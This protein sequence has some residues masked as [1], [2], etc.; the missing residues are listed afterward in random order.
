MDT[1]IH[2]GFGFKIDS[3]FF[4]WKDGV[5]YQ[6]PYEHNGRYFGLRKL[7]RKIS[8]SGWEY[9]HLR[10]KKVGVEKLRAMLQSVDW[11]VTNPHE[12]N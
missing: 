9:Y 12:L 3:V 7:R 10:R 6:L 11:E 4:G 1:K 2:I 8:K 5:L